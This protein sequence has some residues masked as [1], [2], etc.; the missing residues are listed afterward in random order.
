VRAGRRPTPERLV[1]LVDLKAR[2]LE[3][4][5]DAFGELVPGVVRHMLL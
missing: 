5:D 1:L 2:V 4:S 3:V